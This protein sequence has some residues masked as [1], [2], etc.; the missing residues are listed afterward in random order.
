MRNLDDEQ[1][2]PF[3][4][5]RYA[6]QFW[7]AHTSKA[8]SSFRQSFIGPGGFVCSFLEAN[9]LEWV[10]Y[11][12]WNDDLLVAIEGLQIIRNL[13]SVSDIQKALQL[14]HMSLTIA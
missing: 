3:T 12:S 4:R 11:L 13:A 7:I 14:S 2:L 9:L 8:D 6:A 5:V 1:F 10:E